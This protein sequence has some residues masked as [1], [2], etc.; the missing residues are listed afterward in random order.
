MTLIAARHIVAGDRLA[1]LQG[2]VGVL[3]VSP[4]RGRTDTHTQVFLMMFQSHSQL[5]LHPEHLADWENRGVVDDLLMERWIRDDY[6]RDTRI[7]PHDFLVDVA[8]VS[9]IR[10]EVNA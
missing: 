7:Y 1:T 10:P 2:V 4:R 5:P 6:A 8:Q 9:P 3:R